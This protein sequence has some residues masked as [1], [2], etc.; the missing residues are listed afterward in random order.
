MC[1]EEERLRKQS[2]WE[3]GQDDVDES[4]RF[5]IAD[6]SRPGARLD[7]SWNWQ[8]GWQPTYLADALAISTIVQHASM[9]SRVHTRPFF[10]QKIG[11]MDTPYEREALH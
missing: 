4:G 5:Q 3:E 7:V 10:E 8:R 9:A 11:C 6:A 2:G 1:E